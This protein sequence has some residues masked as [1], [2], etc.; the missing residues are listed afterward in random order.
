VLALLLA[1]IAGVA[2]LLMSGLLSLQ[3]KATAVRT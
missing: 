2:T 1:A 3:A